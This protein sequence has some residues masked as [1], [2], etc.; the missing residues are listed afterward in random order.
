[1]I[2][3]MCYVRNKENFPY[4][5]NDLFEKQSYIYVCVNPTLLA[6]VLKINV[7]NGNINIKAPGKVRTF[8]L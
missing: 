4:F 5:L 1:M 6:L 2:I 8:I 7:L 3:V